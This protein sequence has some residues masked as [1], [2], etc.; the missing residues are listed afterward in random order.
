MPSLRDLDWHSGEPLPHPASAG[1]RPARRPLPSS[2]V[3]VSLPNRV[4]LTT[5]RVSWWRRVDWSVVIGMSVSLFGLGYLLV[6]LMRWMA[7]W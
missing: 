6:H 7:R 5:Y 2:S 4:R 1:R 3:V